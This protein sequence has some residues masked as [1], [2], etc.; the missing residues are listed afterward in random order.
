MLP[1]SC[2]SPKHEVE[3]PGSLVLIAGS[4]CR[5]PK[6]EAA[7][8]ATASLAIGKDGKVLLAR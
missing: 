7:M 8:N 5:H 6:D 2:P 1:F 3:D 4:R